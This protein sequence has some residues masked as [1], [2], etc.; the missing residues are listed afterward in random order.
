MFCVS[1]GVDHDELVSLADKH[2]GN[3]SLTHEYEIPAFKKCRF[4]GSEVITHSFVSM[5]CICHVSQAVIIIE[6]PTNL[7]LMKN[8][9]KYEIRIIPIT[10]MLFVHASFFFC[11][12]YYRMVNKDIHH[13]CK[14][15]FSTLDRII[16]ELLLVIHCNFR[17][18]T[19]CFYDTRCSNTENSIF[20]YPTCTFDLD[21]EG[22]AV[23]V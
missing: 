5:L 1:A 22:H 6:K 3:V 19:H 11:L 16:C 21:F 7:F 17:C 23:G 14:T 8:G 20:A 18:I 15:K 12:F 13:S 9:K 4:T 2:F 10:F